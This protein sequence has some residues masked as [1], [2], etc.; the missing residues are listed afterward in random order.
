MVYLY[1]G[2]TAISNRLFIYATQM[3]LKSIMLNERRQKKP[4]TKN[5]LLYI[6]VVFTPLYTF[7]KTHIV[8]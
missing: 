4:H 3:N 6:V 7:V 1:N 8:Y 5:V 2:I